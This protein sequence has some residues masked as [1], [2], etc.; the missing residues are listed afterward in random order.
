M[1]VTPTSGARHGRGRRD[2][3]LE[4]V[5][6][7]AA[8]VVV[9]WHN[10]LGFFPKESGNFAAFH[11]SGARAMPWFGLVYGSAAVTVFFVL[12]GLVLSRAY[13]LTGDASIVARGALKRWP[14]LAGPVVLAVIVSSLLDRFDL[15]SFDQVAGL[16][17]S[18]WLAGHLFH[19]M[20]P[21][22]RGLADALR[23]GTLTFFSGDAS[24]D[25]SLWTMRYETTGSYVVFGLV[26]IMGQLRGSAGATAFLLIVYMLIYLYLDIYVLAF[27]AGVTVARVQVDRIRRL[28]LAAGAPLAV[29]AIFLLGYSGLDVGWY[30]PVA[31]V[32]RSL[33][34]FYVNLAGAVLIIVAADATPQLNAVLRSRPSAFLGWISFPLY[35]I[36]IPILCSIGCSAFLAILPAAGPRAAS[37]G[38]LLATVAASVVASV[39]LAIANDAWTAAVDRLA[40]RFSA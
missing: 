15:Y 6:G 8:V 13:L 23:Q 32:A 3:S 25:S 24:Y 33:N 40:R 7:F 19:G 21:D 38:A 12:S 10:L 35:L 20:Q 1:E 16:T 18:P 17:G 9:L 34:P 39:P 29:L 31:A 28:P 37:V 4:G 26:L 11:H 36:H 5:R 27:V 22:A 14:R 30:R 2:L